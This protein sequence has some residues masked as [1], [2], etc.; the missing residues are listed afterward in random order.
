MRHTFTVTVEVESDCDSTIAL[1][2]AICSCIAGQSHGYQNGDEPEIEFQIMSTETENA[3]CD[4]DLARMP[5]M[6]QGRNWEL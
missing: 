4:T 2:E 1:E 3:N 6:I 5:A